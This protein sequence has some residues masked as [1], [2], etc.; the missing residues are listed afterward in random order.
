MRVIGLCLMLIC[1]STACATVSAGP[2]LKAVDGLGWSGP[3]EPV[4]DDRLRAYAPEEYLAG[5]AGHGVGGDLDLSAACGCAESGSSGPGSGG[6][7][8]SG[9]GVEHKQTS[10]LRVII[11]VPEVQ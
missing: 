9:P 1:V 7:P 6:G 2:D 4:E 5:L 8:S 3:I 11:V 10:R